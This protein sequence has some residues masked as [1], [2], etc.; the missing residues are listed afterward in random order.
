MRGVAARSEMSADGR[1]EEAF[2]DFTSDRGTLIR[3]VSSNL[4]TDELTL[5]KT[6]GAVAK[7]HL[8]V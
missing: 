3:P 1:M 8:T 5:N 6:L 7:A 4:H 2:R